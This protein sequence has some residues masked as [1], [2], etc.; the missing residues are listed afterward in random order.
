[1]NNEVS[2][3]RLGDWSGISVTG[4]MQHG[5]V[6]YLVDRPTQARPQVP[7]YPHKRIQV[8]LHLDY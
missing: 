3:D 7:R 8:S 1:V 2:R 4:V 5:G 6:G